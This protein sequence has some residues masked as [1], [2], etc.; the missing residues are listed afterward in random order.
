MVDLLEF[1][2]ELKQSINDMHDL[3]DTNLPK[4]FREAT[5]KEITTQI[6]NEIE[7]SV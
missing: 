4:M 3:Y 6:K 1:K 5:M 7:K 2:K